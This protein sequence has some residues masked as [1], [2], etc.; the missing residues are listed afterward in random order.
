[1]DIN[2]FKKFTLEHHGLILDFRSH[3]YLDNQ[4]NLNPQY[5]YDTAQRILTS[6]FEFWDRYDVNYAM[7]YN[8]DQ[9]INDLRSTNLKQ[10]LVFWLEAEMHTYYFA[11]LQNRNSYSKADKISASSLAHAQRI[12]RGNKMFIGTVIEIGYGVN[13]DG[14]ILNPACVYENG[15]WEEML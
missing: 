3:V 10:Q 9:M 15:R 2:E 11:E 1:M 14:F 5:S 4:H 6:L 12:A 8:A 7:R 13:S